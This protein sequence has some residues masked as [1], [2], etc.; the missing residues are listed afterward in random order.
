MHLVVGAT[1]LVGHAVAIELAKSG[2]QV[3]ALAR[4]GDDDQ[5]V[6]ALRM[7]GVEIVRGDLKDPASVAAA[8]RGVRTVVST[9]SSTL[10]AQQGD[11]IETVDRAGQ[12]GL[13]DAAQAAGIRRFIFV[14][15]S[16]HLDLD[17]PLRNA[18][19][20][21][22]GRVRNSGME[23]TILRPTM[24]MEVWLSPML[25]FD[26]AAGR[27]RIYGSGD[28]P[29]S[30]ISLRDVVRYTVAAARGHEA[31]RN[32]VLELGGS[33]AV[34]PLDVVRT[35]ERVMGRRFAVEHVPE[36]VLRAQFEAATEPM[37]KSFAGFMLGYAWGDPI[38]MSDTARRFGIQPTSL[39]DF[40]SRAAA[41]TH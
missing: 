17:T 20:E 38:D 11:S 16:G 18:K 27:A 25:G 23:Y 32:N 26:A 9:A 34:S 33:N 37:Q 40:A 14:S 24:F 22:E 5:R 39:E 35:F 30:W 19:R 41:S 10:S 2:E 4:R 1:G 15:F 12:L 7:A 28:N 8:C 31:A 13:V 21:V 6:T 3:R 36:D 29:I